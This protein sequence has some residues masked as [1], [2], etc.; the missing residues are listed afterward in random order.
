MKFLNITPNNLYGISYFGQSVAINS[1]DIAVVGAYGQDNYGKVYIY[2]KYPQ[3]WN[4]QKIKEIA[5]LDGYGGDSFGYS[6]DINYKGDVMAIS[7]PNSNSQVGAVYIYTG[8][9]DSW[10]QVEKI[11]GDNPSDYFG[12]NIDLNQSGDRLIIGSYRLDDSGF[13]D[14]YQGSGNNWNRIIRFWDSGIGHSISGALYGA[15]VAINT[16]DY[17]LISAYD[18]EGLGAVYIYSETGNWGELAVI[19]G[20]SSGNLTSGLVQFGKSLYVTDDARNILI[21]SPGENEGSG[22]VYLFKYNYLNEENMGNYIDIAANGNYSLVLLEDG[23]VKGYGDNSINQIDFPIEISG[24]VTGI[25]AGWTHSIILLKDGGVTG[26][27]YNIYGQIDIPNEISGNVSKIYAGDSYNIAFLKDD[28]ITGWGRNDLG[29]INFPIEVSGNVTGVSAGGFHSLALLKDGSVTGWGWN[30]DGQINIPLDISGNVASIGA[31][32]YHSLALLKDG[33]ITGWGDDSE[34]QINIPVGIGTNATG[35]SAGWYHSL[36]LLKDGS[37]TGWGSNGFGQINIP[38]DI[39]GNVTGI[40]VGEFHSLALLKNGGVVAWGRNTQNQL[41]IPYYPFYSNNEYELK[42]RFTGITSGFGQ[43]TF[44]NNSG[45]VVFASSLNNSGTIYS[46]VNIG[47]TW[48]KYLT[49][50]NLNPISGSSFGKNITL[51]RNYDTMIVGDPNYQITKGNAYVL[52]SPW[53]NFINYYGVNE[54]EVYNYCVCNTGLNCRDCC[55]IIPN[56]SIITGY[57][58]NLNNL[59]LEV[60]LT[61]ENLNCTS[62]SDIYKFYNHSAPVYTNIYQLGDLGST[63][64]GNILIK[65]IKPINDLINLEWKVFNLGKEYKLYT[66]LNINNY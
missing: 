47:S 40:V 5:P 21:G 52:S 19:T 39:S 62:T 3:E 49:I 16:G 41:N 24:N 4:W 20:E 10:Y 37:V 63:Y 7:A 29:Q 22:M 58:N 26:F 9:D 65:N 14:L 59:N 53:D 64:S 17:V 45:N 43:S 51:N 42:A 6:V 44:I 8:K 12:W 23:T 57:V 28:N 46:Y 38:L 34:G 2:K 54:S 33:S 61:I 35:I 1:G 31:G 15:K 18:Q 66:G 11:D 36:A 56:F 30:A 60:S 32:G 13:A 50:N 25:A 48:Y 55:G 27:G